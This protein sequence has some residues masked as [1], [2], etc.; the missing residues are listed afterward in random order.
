MPFQKGNKLGKGRGKG[1]RNIATIEKQCL[2]DYLKDEG[3]E[4]FLQELNTLDGEKYCKIYK[5]IVELAYPKLARTELTGKDGKDLFA[6][7]IYDQE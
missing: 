1:V 3:A 5:D 7:K 6:D 2:I 4:K